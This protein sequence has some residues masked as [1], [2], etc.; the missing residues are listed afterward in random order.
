MGVLR[1]DCTSNGRTEHLIEI[2]FLK[3]DV[4]IENANKYAL[5]LALTL[6]ILYSP[7]TQICLIGYSNVTLNVNPQSVNLN[8]YIDPVRSNIL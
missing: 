3:K 8:G 2:C 7:V 1:I 6:Y 5:N 4:L